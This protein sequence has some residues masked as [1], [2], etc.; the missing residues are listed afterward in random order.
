MN[1]YVALARKDFSTRLGSGK[2]IQDI[3]FV[4]AIEAIQFWTDHPFQVYWKTYL[5]FLESTLHEGKSTGSR[6]LKG[7]RS[8][9]Y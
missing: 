4:H 9:V 1:L 2:D 7:V 5:G 6:A 8:T 3:E